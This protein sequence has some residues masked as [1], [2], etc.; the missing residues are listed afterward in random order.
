MLYQQDIFIG[1]DVGGGSQPYFVAVLN[2]EGEL[3]ALEHCTLEEVLKFTGGHHAVQAAINAPRLM[4][5]GKMA[6]TEFR[7]SLKEQPRDGRYTDIRV[8][9]YLLKVQKIRIAPG[10]VLSKRPAQ[11]I[12]NGFHLYRKY[13]AY[14][15]NTG[16]ERSIIEVNAQAAFS[17]LLGRTPFHKTSIEGRIQRQLLLIRQ[18]IRLKDPMDFFEEVTK[19]KI[20]LGILP[21][22]LVYSAKHLD[23]IAAAM[24]ARLAFQ[25]PEAVIAIG[26]MADGLITIPTVK[27][28]AS[29]YPN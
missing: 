17:I 20:L 15:K 21:D 3:M 7:G 16:G 14:Q 23:A 5:S 22:H 6:N 25:D 27:Q 29:H 2:A 4:P 26:D 12:E 1:V 8:A 9:E 13:L 28:K 11:W 18:G 24:M 19:F 10:P